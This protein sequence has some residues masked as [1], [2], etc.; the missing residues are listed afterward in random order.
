MTVLDP[1]FLRSFLAIADTGS[2]SA[3]AA[4]VNKTQSTVSAQMKRLEELLNVAL[5]DKVG[6]KNALSPE[7][8]K[9]LNYARSIV[10]LHDET[11]E[12]FQ[13][14]RSQEVIRLG[15]SDDYAQAF[16][17][18][19]LR[20]FSRRYPEVEVQMLT[21]DSRSL[22]QP[23]DIGE[24]DV[25][26][27]SCSS[28][29]GGLEVLRTDELHW[30]GREGSRLHE[31]KTIPLALWADGCAWRDMGLAAL[32]AG[33]RDF[34]VMHTTSNAPL[35]RSV[36]AEGIAITVGPQW[37]LAKDTSVLTAMDAACPVGRDSV[38]LRVL[39]PSISDTLEI[40]LDYLRASFRSPEVSLS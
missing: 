31:H 30:I 39:A 29:V 12:I 5:F 10:R 37:Y 34:R 22:R 25:I 36:V 2:Y 11:I 15:M 6:R 35:L 24:F 27:A 23:D 18:P 4:R 7:G 19:A 17:M 28:G 33:E 38:G 26:V 32:A 3:A 1:E 9:L 20:K 14:R 16:L 8:M 13:P 40:F 21:S